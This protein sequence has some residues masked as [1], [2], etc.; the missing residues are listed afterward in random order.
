[1]LALP[2]LSF[3]TIYVDLKSDLGEES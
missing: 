1:L 3:L 2:F